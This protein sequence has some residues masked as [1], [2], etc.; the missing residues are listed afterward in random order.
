[1]NIEKIKS[2]IKSFKVISFDLFDTLFYRPY[3]NPN[4]L[5]YH[6]QM[7]HKRPSYADHRVISEQNARILSLREEIAYD[8]IYDNIDVN[9]RDMKDKELSL[10]FNTL[11]VNKEI[12]NL[13]E[14]SKSLE[15]KIIFVSD[16]YLPVRYIEKLLIKFN[17]NDYS[18]LYVSSD[19]GLTKHSGN[20]FIKVIS[21]LNCTPGDI[22]HIGDNKNSDFIIPKKLGIKA[23][24]YLSFN[25]SFKNS[26]ITKKLQIELFEK[27]DS[28]FLQRLFFKQKINKFNINKKPV[29]FKNYW[30]D[31]GYYYGSFIAL[32]YYDI[33]LK[34]FNT[35]EDELIFVGRDGYSLKLFFDVLKP[36]WKSHYIN[37]PRILVEKCSYPINLNNDENINFLY[38]LL[39][40]PKDGKSYKNKKEIVLKNIQYLE[41]LLKNKKS[42]YTQYLKNSNINLS[43]RLVI[44]DT[45]TGRFTAQRFL[46]SISKNKVF[47]IYFFVRSNLKHDFNY[48]S[49]CDLGYN[50]S[51]QE[52]ES[53]FIQFVEYIL[54]APHELA[55]DIDSQTF[56][57]VFE[58]EDLEINKKREIK[59]YIDRGTKNGALLMKSLISDDLYRVNSKFLIKNIN[60]FI[61]YPEK[62]DA[63]FF[64]K[65]KMTLDHKHHD[66]KPFL[67]SDYS[68]FRL[69]FSP[70]N[71]I[72]EFNK[73][74][75]YYNKFQIIAMAIRYPIL[76]KSSWKKKFLR[77]SIF[78][79]L[80]ETIVSLQVVFL[81]VHRIDFNIGKSAKLA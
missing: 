63:H 16:V 48:E 36:Q 65:I 47:G 3:L 35:V 33:L 17:I 54:S 24:R 52:G 39:N 60:L 11:L 45:A 62:C 66:Y 38:D 5:F 19:S 79:Y 51:P 55:I 73:R 61:N 8:D 78:P 40:Q 81:G 2:S 50:R 59:K 20:L 68:F 41:T 64:Q 57:L 53:H 76:V 21:D 7:L 27:E 32:S 75:I 29:S 23:V 67:S 72:R 42:A 49:V 71:E 30:E 69:I 37:L 34:H 18:A 1:M 74:I 56:D 13:Y 46:S 70:K 26:S 14:Y 44:I 15:K 58:K 22:L 10:E 6:L 25:D 9:F 4:D 31:I 43:K 12:K 77:I 80:N 28:D